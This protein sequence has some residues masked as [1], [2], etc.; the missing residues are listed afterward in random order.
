MLLKNLVSCCFL[1]DSRDLSR[2]SS[3]R[4]SASTPLSRL[5][6]LVKS[7]LASVHFPRLTRACPRRNRALTFSELHSSTWEQA[8]SASWWRLHLA[9]ASERFSSSAASDAAKSARSC[10][11]W[12]LAWRSWHPI[13]YL[14]HARRVL[15]AFNARVPCSFR[16]A[17]SL[18]RASGSSA[19]GKL[20]RTMVTRSTAC[21]SVESKVIK[22]ARGLLSTPA[23]QY[24]GDICSSTTSPAVRSTSPFSIPSG[25]DPSPTM[26]STLVVGASLHSA[27]PTS[28]RT[29]AQS[30][31]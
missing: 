25:T 15:V 28:A 27:S 17:A 21:D 11:S 24:S 26:K 31:T 20:T 16:L 23:S 12:L 4:T 2:C 1:W 19:A 5:R 10:R 8:V 3:F 29:C 30:A 18:I 22:S 6:A 9:A 14:S 7:A 13:L